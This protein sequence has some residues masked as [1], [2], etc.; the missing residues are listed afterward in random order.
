LLPNSNNTTSNNNSKPYSDL[1]S[2]ELSRQII[3]QIRKNKEAGGGVSNSPAATITNLL[4]SAAASQEQSEQQQTEEQPPQQEQNEQQNQPPQPDTNATAAP[5]KQQAFAY[6]Q[7]Q[8]NNNV[9]QLQSDKIAEIAKAAR[10]EKHIIYIFED[11]PSPPKLGEKKNH[12]ENLRAQEIYYSELPN[13]IHEEFKDKRARILD[14]Q[15]I[16]AQ[17]SSSVDSNG[18]LIPPTITKNDPKRT[19]ISDKIFLNIN[20]EIK[21]L[22][23][24]LSKDMALWYYGIPKELLPKIESSSL[25]MALEAGLYRENYGI[26]SSSKNSAVF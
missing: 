13:E 21:R 20:T 9:A 12:R 25:S 26:V 5:Q 7:A 14:L 15:N 10:K 8:I 22:E 23:I 1:I 6:L 3:D 4:A 19:G 2:E 16:K 18:N 11:N 24:E 17:M